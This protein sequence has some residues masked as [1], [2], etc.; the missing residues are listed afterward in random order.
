MAI[1]RNYHE[2]FQEAYSGIP[3][4]CFCE[5]AKHSLGEV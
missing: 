4:W 3:Q 2:F 1:L 5:Q